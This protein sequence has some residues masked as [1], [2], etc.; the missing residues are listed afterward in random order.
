[1]A[2]ITIVDQSGNVT[3]QIVADS[4][5]TASFEAAKTD[6]SFVAMT[7]EMQAP[8]SQKSEGK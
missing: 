1:M 7:L 6:S 4:D 3:T 5:A 8:P 2:E